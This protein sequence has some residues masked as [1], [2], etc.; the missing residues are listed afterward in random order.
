MNRGA[1]DPFRPH[2]APQCPLDAV[3]AIRLESGTEEARCPWH[4][5]LGVLRLLMGARV[6][7]VVPIGKTQCEARAGR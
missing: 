6:F 1:R 5:K 2:V 3:Q 7:A 4:L